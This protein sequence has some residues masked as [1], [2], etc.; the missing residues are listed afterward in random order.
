M[1]KKGGFSLFSSSDDSASPAP[2]EFTEEEKPTEL[3]TP[4]VAKDKKFFGWF[5]GKRRKSKKSSKKAKK[6]SKRKTA[7]NKK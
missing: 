3:G 7:H 1:V 4:L 6:S 2:V 5:G